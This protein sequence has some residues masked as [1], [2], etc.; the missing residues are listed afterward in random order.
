MCVC[1]C[2]HIYL[3]ACVRVCMY[4]CMCVCGGG[5][6]GDIVCV[7]GGSRGRR[8]SERPTSRHSPPTHRTSRSPVCAC[9]RERENVYKCVY[10]C[11]SVCV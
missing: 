11:V 1:V 10:V 4:V 8:P 2:I 7:R 9:V 6:G 5:G 3:F